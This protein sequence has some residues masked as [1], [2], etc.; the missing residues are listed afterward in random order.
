MLVALFQSAKGKKVQRINSYPEAKMAL[1][2]QL[3]T[4]Q[5]RFHKFINT[6]GKILFLESMCLARKMTMLLFTES[7]RPPI[8]V[9]LVKQDKNIDY[10]YVK[11]LL[12]DQNRHNESKYFCV[13]CLHGY[14]K[15]QRCMRH[16]GLRL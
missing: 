1:I 16:V 13:R 3:S 12:Y 15:K 11:R 8:N 4:S 10:S 5:H 9:M 6:R 14:T 7:A 2:S